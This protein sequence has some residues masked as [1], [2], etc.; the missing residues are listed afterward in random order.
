MK[1]L[2]PSPLISLAI[3]VIWLLLN[4]VSAGHAVLA[5]LLAV[6]IPQ[7]T[8][9][10]MPEK[11]HIRAPGQIIRLAVIV[12]YDIVKANIDVALRILGPES[13]IKPGYIWIPL[14]IQSPYGIVSLAGI[15][16][17]TPGTLSADVSEDHR[18]LLVHCFHLENSQATIA[19]IKTRY[20]K[21]LM[22]IYQ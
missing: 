18:W 9:R 1:R 14:D 21:P 12:L 13:R 8:Q 7:I 6:I 15:I 11:P 19:E 5:L 20:E 2:L 17:M 4:G 3:I 16:T 10:I 22:E